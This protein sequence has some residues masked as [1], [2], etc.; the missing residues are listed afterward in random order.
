MGME[1]HP[2]EEERLR[3]LESYGIVATLPEATFDNV[4]CMAAEIGDA[5]VALVTL[6]DRTTQWNKARF[7]TDLIEVPK[8]ISF[9]ARAVASGKPLIVDDVSK[10]PRF[11]NFPSVTGDEHVRFYAG[12]PVRAANGLPLGTVCII[13]RHVRTL[14]HHQFVGLR[15]LAGEVEAN[16]EVRRLKATL[17][18]TLAGK[19]QLSRF[20]AH[21]LNGMV[22]AVSCAVAC[23]LKDS[24]L[25]PV[26]RRFLRDMD[27]TVRRAALV[28]RDFLDIAL[29][30][31]GRLRPHVEVI[32]PAALLERISAE[33]RLLA[34]DDDRLRTMF[35]GY[36]DVLA[37]DIE[38]VARIALNFLRNAFKYASPRSPVT[39]STRRVDDA[40]EI[41]VSDQGPGIPEQERE[42]IFEAYERLERGDDPHVRQSS[43]LGLAFCRAA[44]RALGGQ[45]WVEGNADGGSTFGVR[46]PDLRASTTL[47]VQTAVTAPNESTG[48]HRQPG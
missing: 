30:K 29:S 38:L 5:P 22:T 39:L 43:G 13:D 48:G 8:N 15:A 44:A 34:L 7:G 16:L 46:V 3:T 9:C 18:E 4:A 33:T 14:S 2:R 36:G 42:R 21:E 47:P 31:D 20:L 28:T 1:R 27:A 12:I 11:A 10:D 45:V 17:E 26:D 32:A 37:T 35:D 23:L 6:I 19:E 24:A 40:L 41:T 25:G